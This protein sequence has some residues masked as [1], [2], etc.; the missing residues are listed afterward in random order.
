MPPS[1]SNSGPDFGSF[2]GGAGAAGGIIGTNQ[3]QTA[4][5]KFTTAVD[6]LDSAVAKMS[7]LPGAGG[8]GA[9][10]GGGTATFTGFPQMQNPFNPPVAGPTVPNPNANGGGAVFTPTPVGVPGPNPPGQGGAGGGGQGGGNGGWGAPAG[11]GFTPS[12]VA[13]T[14][15]AGLGGGGGM[16][17][18]LARTALSYAPAPVGAAVSGLASAGAAAQPS[19]LA[20]NTL[21]YQSSIY[22][23]GYGTTRIGAM[24]TAGTV[25]GGQQQIEWGLNPSDMAATYASLQQTTAQINPYAT[26]PGSLGAANVMGAMGAAN[27]AN[28]MLSGQQNASA[29]ANL[30]NPQTS[31]NMMQMGYPVTPDQAGTGAHNPIPNVLAPLLNRLGGGKPMTQQQLFAQLAPG[32]KGNIDLSQLTG[33]N[34]QMISQYSNMLG[35]QNALMTGQNKQKDMSLSQVD[36]TFSQLSSGNTAT[37]NQGEA[38]LQKYGI[39][40][41]AGQMLKSKAGNQAQSVSDTSQGFINGLKTSTRLISDF[42]TVLHKVINSIPGGRGVVGFLEST[43]ANIFGGGAGAPGGVAQSSANSNQV[44][45]AMSSTVNAKAG[46]AVR[47][48]ESQVGV[49]YAYGQESPGE[50]FDCSALPQWAYKSVGITLPRTATDQLRALSGNMVSTQQVQEGDLV[51]QAGVGQNAHEAMVVDQGKHII[52]ARGTG[53]PISIRDYNHGEWEKAARPWQQGKSLP[54]NAPPAGSQN[55]R[56]GGATPAA[57]P[58]TSPSSV[59]QAMEKYMMAR[60]GDAYSESNRWGRPPY[61]CSSLL[62]SAANASGLKI[63]GDP[64]TDSGDVLANT[65][66]NWIGE[67]KG[68]I[69]NTVASKIQTDDIIFFTG[70][71]PGPSN[72]GGIGHVGMAASP[73]VMIS[74]YDTAS[75]VTTTPISQDHFV[76]GFTLPGGTAAPGGGGGTGTTTTTTNASGGTS[77]LGGLSAGL[78]DYETE[79]STT[80][81]SAFGGAIVG[82]G[83]G[84]ATTSDTRTTTA[85]SPSSSPSSSPSG[86]TPTGSTTLVA[87]GKYLM[88]AG[89]SKAAAAGAAGVVGGEAEPAGTANPESIGSGGAGLIGWTPPSTMEQYGGT[90]KAAGIG[91]NSTA[92]DMEN[93]EKAMVKWMTA[94]GWPPPQNSFPQTE[95]GALQAASSASAAYERPQVPGSDV[96]AQ[97]V[98]EVWNGLAAGGTLPSGG[99]AWVGE[100]GPE[101]ISVSQDSTVH[102]AASS[103]RLASS[104]M[105]QPAQGP[106]SAS[107]TSSSGYLYSTAHP[108]YG[109]GNSTNSNGVQVTFA[110]GAVVINGPTSS[111]AMSVTG[112]SGAA[113]AQ[114]FSKQLQSELAKINLA[115]AVGSGVSS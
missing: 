21:Q 94:N 37:F 93:Q 100:R 84:G 15:A 30:Y 95:A 19:Q 42:N 81:L 53:I 103:I 112:N 34:A 111:S 54:K 31:L 13:G 56:G 16:L 20:L 113:A 6:K 101:L 43:A 86:G 39:P 55:V 46:Q 36:T 2:E 40:Q 24:G 58:T 114:T 68:V 5:D 26:G 49:P 1:P 51:F 74:A 7:S 89:Y 11:G 52:E 92:V 72:Y 73:T 28:P 66:A 50:G 8:G 65:E 17:G 44:K 4:I 70:A 98:D 99:M 80:E 78:G 67:Q 96:H 109:G 71:G 110:S 102:D 35:I 23:Q 29:I 83:L 32:Q 106:W 45:L 87:L 104:A 115:C 60:K 14:V 69:K 47:L 48:A 62:W 38:T 88:S 12:N 108:L 107:G 9:G 85:A 10:T 22:G 27:I 105:A 61:D 76:V 3:L 59:A 33:G 79:G 41:S 97:W 91:N 63:P 82:G 77:G 25:M 75:G 64:S 90:C 18:G 57:A